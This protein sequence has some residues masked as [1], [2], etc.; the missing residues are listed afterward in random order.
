MNSA[1]SA[2][3]SARSECNLR[4]VREIFST[5][6]EN[7]DQVLGGLDDGLLLFSLDGRAVMVSP[8]VERFL[9]M[10][11][12]QLLGRRAE[13]IFPPDHPV[14]E[15]IKLIDGEFEPVG[16]GRGYSGRAGFAGAAR[17]V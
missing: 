3:K 14:R 15:A 4:G 7:L 2:R 12:D 16:V 9:S 1:K 8:A 11:A 10:P 6:R 13:D 5:L 17:R